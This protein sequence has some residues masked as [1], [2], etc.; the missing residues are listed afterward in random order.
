MRH[1]NTQQVRTALI[2]IA[3]QS[4]RPHFGLFVVREV[5]DAIINNTHHNLKNAVLSEIYIQYGDQYKP[6]PEFTGIK[7][8]KVFMEKLLRI[9][10]YYAGQKLI[11]RA[12]GVSERTIS[13]L[14]RAKIELTFNV[15]EK[16]L[17]VLDQV[18][19]E[20]EAYKIEKQ[21]QKH[22]KYITYR[23]GCRCEPCRI[24]WRMYIKNSSQRKKLAEQNTIEKIA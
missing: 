19:T 15:W 23:K 17:P 14:L 20:L 5:K 12:S 10:D 3:E 11:V 2:E 13:L 24:A 4:Q 6:E 18:L 1:I 21:K 7:D 9:R 16:I 8:Q 22:G